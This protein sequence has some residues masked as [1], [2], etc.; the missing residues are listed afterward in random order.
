MSIILVPNCEIWLVLRW[1][2]M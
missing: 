1:Q 2:S